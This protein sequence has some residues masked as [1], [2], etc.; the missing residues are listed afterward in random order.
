[1]NAPLHRIARLLSTPWLMRADAHQSLVAQFKQQVTQ[2]VEASWIQPN[3]DLF[4][5]PKEVTKHNCLNYVDIAEGVAVVKIQGILGRH[6]KNL[7][8]MCGGYDLNILNDQAMALMARPDVH[9]VVTHWISPGGSAFGLADCARILT[10]LGAVK[11]HIAYC[12]EACSAAYWLASTAEVVICGESACMGSIGCVCAID[13]VSQMYEELGIKVHLFA[14]GDFKGAG[15]QGTSLTEGQ[16]ENIQA[17]VEHLGDMFKEAVR[18]R[19]PGVAESTM[20]GQWFSGRQA[21]ELGLA[22]V[23]LPSID[24]ALAFVMTA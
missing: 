2:R 10:D 5:S 3:G 16:K 8:T 7:E 6:L 23:A 14:D 20:Q 24:H 13:D 21:L 15:T 18:S 1:M 19:R 4:A 12:D 9:T 11:T 22:D 17:Q